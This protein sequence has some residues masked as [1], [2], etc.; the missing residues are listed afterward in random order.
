MQ[1]FKLEGTRNKGFT[2]IE[3]LIGIGLT[4]LLI[5]LSFSILS[6]TSKLSNE[7]L[8]LDDFLLQGRFALEYIKEDILD[9][10][11]SI[12]SIEIISMQDYLPDNFMYTETL[13]F[14]I[15]K[16][17]LEFNH[18]FYKL[19]DEILTR[20]SF[21]SPNK[22]PKKILG[23]PGDNTILK[24]V[25]SL[26]DSYFDSENNI[27]CMIIQTKDKDNNKIYNFIETLYLKDDLKMRGIE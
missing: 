7:A 6:I 16:E 12:K 5:S 10:D 8:T 1:N 9:I 17:E 3:L 21:K 25:Y 18:I 2:L 23:K 4:S 22:Y 11:K 24:N 14:F 13:G 26:K 20:I 15:I 27:L 19:E